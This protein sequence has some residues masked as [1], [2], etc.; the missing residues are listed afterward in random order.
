MAGIALLL[1]VVL[2]YPACVGPVKGLYPPGNSEAAKT[3]YVVSHGWHTGIVVDR[4]DIPKGVWKE[5]NLF[6]NARWIEVGW[7]DEAFYQAPDPS[8]WV[9]C[10]AVFWP[11]P[12]ALHVVSFHEPVASFFPDSR[13]LEIRLSQ[14]GFE[15][16]ARFIEDSYLRG[17][18]G[19][20]IP[21]GPGLYGDG[22]FFRARGKFFALRTCNNWT[23]RALRSAG[24]PITPPYAVTAG[25][26]FFQ[27]R[28]FG[29]TIESEAAGK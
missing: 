20:V 3:V 16:L 6:P 18:D 19:E 5:N 21:L 25:N 23:A 27:A 9:T 10:K 1:A 24:C 4:R 29:T 12:S 22:R 11:T 8:M 17:V 13:L 26:L 14:R 15:R 28:K 2:T 7:G